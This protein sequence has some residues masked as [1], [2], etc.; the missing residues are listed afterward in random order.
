MYRVSDVPAVFRLLG[1]YDFGGQTATLRFAIR[2]TFIPEN[3]GAVVV[4][5]EGG[6]AHVQEGD[7][8]G[9][10]AEV[11]L[12][13]AE[14]SSLLMGCVPFERLYV[15]GLAG[16]SDARQVETVDRIFRTREKPMC[17]TPF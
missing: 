6:R 12:D 3:E 9:V 5:F 1:A 15:Y 13:V 10:D 4:R 11:R 14:F 8:D 2:D 17:M 16:I 7:A